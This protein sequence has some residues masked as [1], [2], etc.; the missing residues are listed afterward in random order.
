MPPFPTPILRDLCYQLNYFQDNSTP[1][2]SCIHFLICRG[3]LL[4]DLLFSD[5]TTCFSIIFAAVAFAIG[6]VSE[7]VF[8]SLI[9][10]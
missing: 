7:V 6:I 5:F 3:C 1:L 10:V 2:M 9:F 4:D 8:Y